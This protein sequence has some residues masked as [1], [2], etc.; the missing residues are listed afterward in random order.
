MLQ[1]A[2]CALLFKLGQAMSVG[3]QY[4]GGDGGGSGG[5]NGGAGGA[6]D[7]DDGG[8]TCGVNYIKYVV[9]AVAVAV[10]VA[11]AVTIAVAI[12]VI[13]VIL[14]FSFD[15]NFFSNHS[16]RPTN[17]CRDLLTVTPYV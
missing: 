7:V 6:G 13:V 4:G 12:V 2:L 11:I 5:G 8:G 15:I 10:A 3:W 17:F 9:V 16:L 14:L 1:H